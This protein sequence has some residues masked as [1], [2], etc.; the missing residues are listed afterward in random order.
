MHSFTHA[1]RD[2]SVNSPWKELLKH[3]PT[4]DICPKEFELNAV[5]ALCTLFHRYCEIPPCWRLYYYAMQRTLP[6]DEYRPYSSIYDCIK[7]KWWLLNFLFIYIYIW[8]FYLFI[9]RERE[10]DWEGKKHQCVVVSRMPP[11]GDLACNPGMCPDLESN[12]RPFGS[13]A[14]TVLNPLS[15]TSQ[16]CYIFTI[17]FFFI[18]SLNF[19]FGIYLYLFTSYCE[20]C[21]P[22]LCSWYSGT[23]AWRVFS[24]LEKKREVAAGYKILAQL[25]V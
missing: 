23:C 4:E 11:T 16:A 17:I 15:H 9:G 22:S 25:Y 5:L 3:K 24:K 1:L 7:S 8:R 10:G 21:Y 14:G 18:F 12:R 2:S 6:G 13:Q 20:L 19:L